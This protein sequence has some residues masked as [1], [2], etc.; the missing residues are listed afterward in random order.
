MVAHKNTHTG[1]RKLY[2]NKTRSKLHETSLSEEEL[3]ATSSDRSMHDI[4]KKTDMTGNPMM[5][6]QMGN[7]MMNNPMMNPMMNSQMNPMMNQMGNPM[8]NNQMNPMMD[9]MMN[10]MM[11]SQMNPMMDYSMAG[12]AI[13]TMEAIDPLTIQTFAPV[14]N[15]Q[16]NNMNSGFNMNSGINNLALLNNNQSYAGAMSY[17]VNNSDAMGNASAMSYNGNN[18]GAMNYEAYNHNNIQSRANDQSFN[19]KNL[20]NLTQ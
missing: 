14:N 18:S 6:N 10:P 17:N 7:P 19:L 11:N 5:N 12:N 9:S 20:A 1:T 3:S 16:S 8:M 4:L 15:R 13:N 2:S